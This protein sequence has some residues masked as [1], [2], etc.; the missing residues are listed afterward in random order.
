MEAAPTVTLLPAKDDA[1]CGSV[2]AADADSKSGR[3]N[4]VRNIFGNVVGLDCGESRCSVGRRL[5]TTAPPPLTRLAEDSYFS[6]RWKFGVAL[7]LVVM[8]SFTTWGQA[9]SRGGEQDEGRTQAAA[10]THASDEGGDE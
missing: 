3:I 4:S 7:S 1:L 9:R 5:L 8:G 6:S 2:Y 10:L